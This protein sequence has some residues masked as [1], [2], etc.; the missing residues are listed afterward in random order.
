MESWRREMN[1]KLPWRKWFALLKK[2][3]ITAK[4]PESLPSGLL[5]STFSR[6][7]DWSIFLHATTEKPPPSSSLVVE[8]QYLPTLDKT[9][10]N[11]DNSMDEDLHD[12]INEANGGPL[13]VID[14]PPYQGPTMLVLILVFLCC[15]MILL[16]GVACFSI[17]WM[18][19]RRRKRHQGS[20]GEV[21]SATGKLL[22]AHSSS[23]GLFRWPGLSITNGGGGGGSCITANVASQPSFDGG[24]GYV[25]V[26]NTGKFVIST[27]KK[28]PFVGQ[29]DVFK[30]SRT[31]QHLGNTKRQ[32]KD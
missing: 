29:I 27:T 30:T 22:K 24:L 21:Q 20:R 3:G 7:N 26:A 12:L 18:Q 16:V 25:A 32:V 13:R 8:T 17:M 31:F 11:A 1:C 6:I 4:L 5:T 2:P 28:P 14:P 19:K 9:N 10:I 15:F 23:V